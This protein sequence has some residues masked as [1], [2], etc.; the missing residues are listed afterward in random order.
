MAWCCQATSHY[1]SQRLLSLLST[2][3]IARPQRVKWC[4]DSFKSPPYKQLHGIDCV[5]SFTGKDLNCMHHAA[6]G[7]LG[8]NKNNCHK[9]SLDT[10]LMDPITLS[11]TQ[12]Y[13]LIFWTTLIGN[14]LTVVRYEFVTDWE[15]YVI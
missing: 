12:N 15:K 1:L 10:H 8:Q 3:G 5:L 2:Y 6:I 13:Q 7:K 9:H 11:L 4:P 14:Q